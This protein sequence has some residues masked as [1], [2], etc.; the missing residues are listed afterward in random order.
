MQRIDMC[1]LLDPE[2]RRRLVPADRRIFL[3]YARIDDEVPTLDPDAKGW[4]RYFYDQ[5]RVALRQRLA[6]EVEFWRDLK[7][8]DENEIFETAIEEGLDGSKLLLTVVSP[9]YLKSKWCSRERERFVARQGGKGSAD[10]ERV[11]KVLKHWLD[12]RELPD[13]LRERTGYRFFLVEP[14]TKRE[15]QLYFNGKLRREAEYTDRVEQLVDYIVRSLQPRRSDPPPARSTVF[16]ALGPNSDDSEPTLRL[17]AELEA[18]GLA[19]VQP[20]AGPI[21][22]QDARRQLDGML[23]TARAAIHVVGRN[24]GPRP[25]TFSLPAVH[26]QLDASGRRAD[27]DRRFRRYILVLASHIQGSPEHRAFVDRLQVDL[28]EGG[29]LRPTDELVLERPGSVTVQEFLSIVRDGLI[30]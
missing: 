6:G 28:S 3:S 1:E 21:T 26:L 30:K 12:E 4:V 25:P 8:I 29:I 20:H 7:D 2:L 17:R 27:R 22:E 16:L 14:E 9:S 13:E 5:L 19:V 10:V 24:A 23:T 15:I 11:I 18:A